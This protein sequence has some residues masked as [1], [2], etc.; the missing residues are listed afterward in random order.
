VTTFDRYVIVDW[1]ASGI[2]RRGR[3]SIWVA[4]LGAVGDPV[5]W[6]PATRTAAHAAIRGHLVDAVRRGERVLIGFDFPYAYPRGFARALG[7]AGEPWRAVWDELERLIR[8]DA[9]R[10]NAS[11][12]FAVAS[13]LNQRLIAHAY[14]GRPAKQPHQHLSMRRDVVR[15]RLEGEEAGLA[16]WRDVERCLHAEKRYPQSAWKLLGAGSVGSQALTGIPVVSRLRADPDLRAVSR[17]WPFEVAVPSLAPGAAGI[18]HAEIWPSQPPTPDLPGRVRDEAQVMALAG[19][20]R[21]QDRDGTLADL[22]AAARASDASHEEGW[23][24]GV[25]PPTPAR[26]L[27]AASATPAPPRRR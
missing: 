14:W 11:N 18:V 10:P 6:N 7:L 16:E 20:F 19:R 1:S 17:V 23:I 15:Y 12:R 4:S 9:P 8:D 26:P 24:L 2:P 13:E 5:T 27:P 3:D 25:T 21:D 22:F